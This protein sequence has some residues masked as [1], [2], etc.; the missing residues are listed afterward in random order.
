MNHKQMK[1]QLLALNWFQKARKWRHP[2]FRKKTFTLHQACITAGIL[3]PAVAK[4][5]SPEVDDTPWHQKGKWADNKPLRKMK[6][7][8]NRGTGRRKPVRISKKPFKEEG[9][10]GT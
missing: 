1:E 4:A 8:S 5:K 7:D 10:V 3:K 9:I 2:R 6:I